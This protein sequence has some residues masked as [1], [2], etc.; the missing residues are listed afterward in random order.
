MTIR[1]LKNTD[2]DAVEKIIYAIKIF[3]EEEKKV[4]ME[5]IDIFLTQPLQK[6]YI[7]EVICGDSDE[8][9]IFGYVC[10]G[11]T[12]M[13]EATY[14]LYWIV[15][16]NAHQNKGYGKKLVEHVEQSCREKGG[17][18]LVVETSSRPDYLPTRSFYE[19]MSYHIEA[20]IKDFYK[21]G[22]DK[23]IYTKKL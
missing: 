8:K 9:E 10:Y 11:P 6:D 7:V 4:A 17:K 14:D 12:P 3:S 16:S 22:D 15:V 5:L 2:R 23:I 18:L 21:T 13:T 19:R 20:R 1:L